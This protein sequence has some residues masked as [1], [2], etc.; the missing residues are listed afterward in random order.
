MLT[1]MGSRLSAV[2]FEVVDV[3]QE[4][5]YEY[6]S[7]EGPHLERKPFKCHIFEPENALLRTP[8]L[9]Q[10]SDELDFSDYY[11]SVYRKNKRKQLKKRKTEKILKTS[12][13]QFHRV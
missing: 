4:E 13:G 9:T 1:R 2:R 7:F 6:F 8:K 11:K 3:W 5:E 12:S 10:I